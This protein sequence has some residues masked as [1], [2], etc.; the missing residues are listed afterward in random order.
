MEYLDLPPP[1]RRK[2][3]E[4]HSAED[5]HK[6]VCR[7]CIANRA[8]LKYAGPYLLGP[9]LGSPPVKS[10]T[11]CLARKMGTD[12]FFTLK[13]L[14]MRDADR[15][16]QDIKQGKMLIHTEFSLLSLL[17]D[18]EGVVHTHGLFQDE[19]EEP[20]V[21]LQ[22]KN[23]KIMQK[24]AHRCKRLC[25][26]LD[27]LTAHDYSPATY[28]MVNLQHYVIKEKKLS[29]RETLVIFL[30]MVVVVQGLHSVSS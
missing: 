26:V 11:Q 22:N 20:L 3:D 9:T 23:M 28:D 5:N 19:V 16:S 29:E 30:D 12:K 4:D 7:K 18:Q 8:S 27:C 24:K 13:L 25:L 21:D 14:T 2:V 6:K 1:K 17:H 10:I 15:N